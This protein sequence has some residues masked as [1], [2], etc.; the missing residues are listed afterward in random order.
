MSKIVE[1]TSLGALRRAPRKGR[2]VD[3]KRTRRS[4]TRGPAA[5]VF[6]KFSFGKLPSLAFPADGPCRLV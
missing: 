4:V 6:V 1:F 2:G 5:G 3:R